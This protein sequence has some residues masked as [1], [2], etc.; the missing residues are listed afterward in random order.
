MKADR[1]PHVVIALRDRN[2]LRRI[3][4]LCAR[5]DEAP[6]AARACTRE[7]TFGVGHGQVAVG[8]GED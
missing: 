7:D 3:G 4:E 2:C 8:V 1:R 6:H 5:N